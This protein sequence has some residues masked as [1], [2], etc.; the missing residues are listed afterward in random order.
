MNWH[1][2]GFFNQ[3]S[4]LAVVALV[5]TILLA[6]LDFRDRSRV[7]RILLEQQ[8]LLLLKKQLTQANQDFLKARLNESQLIN[9]RKAIFFEKFKVELNQAEVLTNELIEQSQDADITAPLTTTL[10]HLEKYRNSVVNTRGLQQEMGLDNSV[11]GI[12]PQLQTLNKSIEKF[13]DQSGEKELIFKFVHMQILEKDFSS[14]LDMRLVN[15]L[16]SIR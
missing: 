4:R 15:Q 7:N 1:R 9:T 8:M 2:L 10:I 12:L 13:L 6:I 11:D 3:F 14:T 16:N 5:V